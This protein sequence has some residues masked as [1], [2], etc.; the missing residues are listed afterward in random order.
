MQTIIALIPAFP[1]LGFFI[2]A[3]F[4][5]KMS[6]TVS[7]TIGAGSIGIAMLLAFWAGYQYLHNLSDVKSY[8]AVAWHWISS[9]NLNVDI[10]FRLDALS[11]IFTLVI[12]FVGFLIHVYSNEY[13]ADD[14]DFNRFFTYMNLFVTSMLLL[15]LADNYLL[16]YLGWEGVGLCSYL[17][18]GFWYKD[19]ANGYAGRKAFIYT[20]TGDVAL[21]LGI[22]ILFVH[23]GT[24]NIQSV[25]HLAGGKWAI[26][27]SIA[28]ITAFLLF[29]GAISKSAQMP[30]Q[31]WLIDAM[32][33]PTPV[34]ALLHSSTMVTAGVYLIARNHALFALAPSIMTLVAIVGAVTL[35]VSGFSGLAHH[36]IK[37]ILAY[38]TVSQIGYMFLALGVGAWSAA[39]FHFMVQ[40]FFKALLFLG[41][42][43]L[44]LAMNQEHNIF[45]MG[46]LRKKMPVVFYTYVAGAAS[47]SAVPL[48]TAGFYSK[49][50]I[51]W[52][53]YASPTGSFWLWI[54][55]IVGA[56]LTT[57]Y[58]FRMVFITFYGKMNTEPVYKPKNL[59]K[60]PLIILAFLS[61]FG[62]LVDFP[63]TLA[64]FHPFTSFMNHTLPVFTPDKS[65]HLEGWF[66]LISAA[67]VLVG[68]YLSYVFFVQ[69]RDAAEAFTETKLNKFFENGWGFD[70]V[71]DVLIVKPVEWFSK[72]DQRDFLDYINVGIARV[73]L[74]FSRLLSVTQNGK[75]R[76]YLMSLTVGI[77][78]ILTYMIYK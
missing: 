67:V 66:E 26:G 78:L 34:S 40:A 72:I 31:P 61:I 63:D 11:L 53:S 65:A 57:L 36:D 20:R 73:S 2:L 37:K 52:Y 41:A 49:D 29:V 50:A 68:I 21:M 69:K 12:T 8:S 74:R 47:L 56:L 24:L 6:K 51:I 14:V 13:M 18:I 42:G 28:V 45:K 5:K 19:P 1:L 25:A 4:G 27:S 76:W 22:I 54:L 17:L 9:G 10:S 59:I 43:A 35:V 38:S 77:V 46:G 44:I 48:I 23:F 58:S 62:G 7:G 64:H 55:A 70:T 3:F 33:G 75:L 39:I 71:Y 30:M 16:M 15:V 60:V 32:A